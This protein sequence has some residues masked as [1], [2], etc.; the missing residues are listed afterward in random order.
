M[1]KLKTNRLARK[2]FRVTG[3]GRVKRSQ[4]NTSHNTGKKS[5]GHMRRL[6]GRLV[7]DKTN[8]KAVK[9]QLPYGGK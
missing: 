1:P 3:K 4:A 7:V 8:E 9:R 2:K 5:A 6:R